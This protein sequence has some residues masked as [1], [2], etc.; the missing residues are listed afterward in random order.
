[1]KFWEKKQVLPS[2]TKESVLPPYPPSE[3]ES[4]AHQQQMVILMNKR[5]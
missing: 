4:K 5:A 3:N 2:E 1:M